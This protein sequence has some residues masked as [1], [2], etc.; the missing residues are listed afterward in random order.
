[1]NRTVINILQRVLVNHFYKVNAGFFLFFFFVLFGVVNGSQL[2]SYHFSLI[3]GMIQSYV[4]LAC[5]IFAWLLYT[6]KCINY[7]T[8]QLSEPGQQF[9]FVL[10]TA[11]RS[12]R[13]IWMLFVHMMVYMPVFLYAVIVAVIAAKQHYFGSMTAVIIS[14]GFMI[15]LSTGLYMR[16][17]Q[18]RV[19]GINFTLSAFQFSKPFFS[20]P[21][22]FLWKERKQMLL[23]TKT[24]SL[25]LLYGFINLYEPDS[26][27]IRPLLLIMMLIA[28][29]HCAIILQLRSFEEERLLFTKNLPV[30]L[31]KRFAW[32]LL[33]YALLLLPELVFMWKG[34]PL[35]FQLKDL[36]Q[37]WLLVISILAF[38]HSIL[39]MKDMDSEHY[40]RIAFIICATLFFILLY[41]PGIFLPLLL[42]LIA[43]ALYRSHLYDFEKK[44]GLSSE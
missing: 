2:I 15:L 42:L 8:K 18:K 9:L 25:L 14:N 27:D 1:M 35:H 26:P 32:L 36:P 22:W 31:L 34:F 39:L 5:V 24:F 28:T 41:D 38:F 37:V 16:Y 10:N 6:L 44:I 33:M 43:Y 13:L 4:F 29:A 19:T 11:P 21:L 12:K 30:P 7:I 23:V 20:I 3:Q 17:L 40:F